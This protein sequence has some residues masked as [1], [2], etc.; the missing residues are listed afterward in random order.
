MYILKLVKTLKM[1]SDFE[2]I[3]EAFLTTHI[4]TSLTIRYVVSISTTF[5][6]L[7]A[8]RSAL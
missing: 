6:D 2:T 3:K 8:N 5:N 4:L 1:S 7:Q